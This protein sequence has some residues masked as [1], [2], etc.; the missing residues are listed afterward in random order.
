VRESRA[1]RDFC[2]SRIRDIPQLSQL[3]GPLFN[4]RIHISVLEIRP[5]LK[6]A[7]GYLP[8]RLGRNVRRC[9]AFE[10]N[11]LF[12]TRLEE[13]LCSTSEMESPLASPESPPDIHRIPFVLEDNIWAGTGTGTS[14]DDEKYDVILFCHSMYG[15]KP[16]HRHFET[17][18]NKWTRRQ[19]KSR[20]R[21]NLAQD[22]WIN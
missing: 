22:P 5:G 8:D 12:A 17:A 7:L 4:S 14:N 9:T 15:M 19:L 1:A 11:G 20:G 21:S 13:W 6:S 16:K 2:I 10:P 3:L 18:L